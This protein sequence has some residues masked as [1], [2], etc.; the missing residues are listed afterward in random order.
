MEFQELAVSVDDTDE[1]VVVGKSSFRF[2]H[3]AMEAV[4]LW[5]IDG[6]TWT[7]GF[8]LLLDQDMRWDA[9][10]NACLRGY[11]FYGALTTDTA[12]SIRETSYE[13]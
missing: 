1:S 11:L 3:M 12:F 4:P 6:L 8:M 5:E 10:E 2:A 9:S 13:H 7:S